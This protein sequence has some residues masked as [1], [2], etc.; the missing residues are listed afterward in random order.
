MSQFGISM[1]K[2]KRCHALIHDSLIYVLLMCLG[3]VVVSVMDS[4]SCNLG[5]NQAMQLH[6]IIRYALNSI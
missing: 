4:Y 6:N 5:S 2:K 3:S 1:V